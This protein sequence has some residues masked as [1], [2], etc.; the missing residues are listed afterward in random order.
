MVKPQ[1]LGETVLSLPE[2]K[3]ELENIKARDTTL[4]FRATKCEEY[5]ND[6]FVLSAAKAVD[7]KKKITDMGIAR[8]KEEHVV[9]IVDLLP[10]TADE[11]KIVLHNVSLSKKDQEQIAAAV[12]ELVR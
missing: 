2:A 11:V 7:L 12:Q 5:F 10:K 8:L 1:L 9:K 4:S 3:A 6:L